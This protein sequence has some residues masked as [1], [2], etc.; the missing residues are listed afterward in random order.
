MWSFNI[1]VIP[2]KFSMCLFR[3]RAN[4][5]RGQRIIPAFIGPVILYSHYNQLLFATPVY[6]SYAP[7]HSLLLIMILNLR[8]FL[9]D[10]HRI[11]QL[12]QEIHV[13]RISLIYDGPIELRYNLIE[14]TLFKSLNRL[15]KIILFS[16]TY[17]NL[18]MEH[19]NA[20]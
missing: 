1:I 20:S 10:F 7:Q 2:I 12:T 13:P 6:P 3:K 19:I 14:N 4:S 16:P 11:I 18:P 17:V 15:L 9:Q 8:N 5:D